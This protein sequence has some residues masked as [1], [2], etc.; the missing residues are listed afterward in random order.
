M[1]SSLLSSSIPSSAYT[2]S[3]TSAD[4]TQP[5]PLIPRTARH[6]RAHTQDLFDHVV[7]SSTTPPSA[8]SPSSAYHDI[9]H[10]RFSCASC[11][12]LLSRAQAP[13]QSFAQPVPSARRGQKRFWKI[14]RQSGALHSPRGGFVKSIPF[15]GRARRP[16][17]PVFPSS[18]RDE[19]A[20]VL[21][22]AGVR[23]VSR[24]ATVR[25]LRATQAEA[26]SS[27][28]ADVHKSTS[29]TVSSSAANSSSVSAIRTATTG[30]AA[31]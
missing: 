10:L 3:H 24:L 16:F 6:P 21:G 13:G 29:S 1:I 7:T 8:S 2:T 30:A 4:V 18:P 22:A 26:C 19:Q 14:P 17:P 5:D 20:G 9:C 27:A 15:T 31:S 12:A 11:P 23:F 28:T 25:R